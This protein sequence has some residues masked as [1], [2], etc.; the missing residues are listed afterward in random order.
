MQWDDSPGAGFT[1]GTP[2]LAP[3][4][5][6]HINVRDELAHGRIFRHYQEL[7]RLRREVPDI[8]DG[9]YAP[10]RLDHEHVYA[11]LRDSVFVACNLTQEPTSIELP[12]QFHGASPLINNYPDDPD[13]GQSELHL[14]PYQAV[15]LVKGES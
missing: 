15:A 5:Q 12:E 13:T 14:A 8:A 3:T 6:E 2:W 11:Y 10:W 4:N 9:S 1:T 7:I